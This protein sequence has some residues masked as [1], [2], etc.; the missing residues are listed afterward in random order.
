MLRLALF[1]LPALCAGCLQ[2]RFHFPDDRQVHGQVTA[3][4][5]ERHSV[6]IRL[7]D[8]RTRWLPLAE[9]NAVDLPGWGGVIA[10]GA[11]AVL[12]G[13]MIVSGLGHEPRSVTDYGRGGAIGLGMVIGIVGGVVAGLSAN[14]R[15]KA[16]DLVD[17]AR[18]TR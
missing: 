7:A 14:E 2:T 9:V 10:G 5:A 4:D 11:M 6:Q 1:M 3:A 15:L 8:G 16:A 17:E 18:G 13:G 12:G